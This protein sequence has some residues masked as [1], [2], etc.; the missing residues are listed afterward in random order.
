MSL[1]SKVIRTKIKVMI[2]APPY[3][4]ATI[5]DKQST[6]KTNKTKATNTSKETKLMNMYIWWFEN[7]M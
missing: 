2:T 1:W 5:N 3:K 4:R 6:R 7:P